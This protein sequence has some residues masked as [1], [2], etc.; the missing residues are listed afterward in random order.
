MFCV[1]VTRADL[2]GRGTLAF[3]KNHHQANRTLALQ[4]NSIESDKKSKIDK[5]VAKW[6]WQVAPSE[7]M[8]VA[9]DDLRNDVIYIHLKTKEKIYTIP[10]PLI[11][12]TM[13]EVSKIVMWLSVPDGEPRPFRP[14]SNL[15]DA[16]RDFRDA[17]MGSAKEKTGD[18]IQL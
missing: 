14:E 7:D 5:V 6:D 13:A 1:S 10:V 16:C 12:F 4:F 15:A 9:S 18:K 3:K 17:F 8:V 2:D 11:V